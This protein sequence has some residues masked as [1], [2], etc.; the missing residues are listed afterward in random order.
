MARVPIER[1]YDMTGASATTADAGGYTTAAPVVPATVLDIGAVKQ[2]PYIDPA[3][4]TFNAD[5]VAALIAAGLM[6]SS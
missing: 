1:E 3:S 4:G 2:M 5:L 6:A